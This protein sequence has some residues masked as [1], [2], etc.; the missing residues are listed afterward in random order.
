MEDTKKSKAYR[1]ISVTNISQQLLNY[2]LI[3][4]ITVHTEDY[5]IQSF[6]PNST[7]RIVFDP[8]LS[9]NDWRILTSA[10]QSGHFFSGD[11]IW[12]SPENN[13]TTTTTSTTTV[14]TTITASPS[15]AQLTPNAILND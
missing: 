4:P 5:Q 2:N 6:N 14:T 1:K 7:Y 10:S 15:L 8:I 13:T 12:K 9:K 11:V 3:S